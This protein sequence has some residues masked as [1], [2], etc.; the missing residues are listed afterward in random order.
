[1]GDLVDVAERIANHRPA[2]AV[3]RVAGRFDR[4]CAGGQRPLVGHVDVDDVH[5][6]ERRE[7]LPFAG[8]GDHEHRI[9]DAQLDRPALHHVAG[10]AE[11]S[12]QE[13]DL[14]GEVGDDDARR[15]RVVAV[16]RR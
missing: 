1:M 2:V 6:Q 13:L 4:R 11:R 14:G 5:V 10:G 3:G 8:L 12:P 15:Q 7:E 16:G 9:A